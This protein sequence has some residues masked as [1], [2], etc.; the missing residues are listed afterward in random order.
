MEDHLLQ[1]YIK[2]TPVVFD[3]E[4]RLY[5]KTNYTII[6]DYKRVEDH[7][8]EDFTYIENYINELCYY[9]KLDSNGNYIT[10]EREIIINELGHKN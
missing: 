10:E 1:L 2:N 4:T 8:E 7:T 5:N 6:S 9:P 3:L